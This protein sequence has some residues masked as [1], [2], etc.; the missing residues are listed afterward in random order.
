M[1]KFISLATDPAFQPFHWSWPGSHQPMHAVMIMLVDLYER[2]HSAEAPISRAY[3]DKV[4]LI[5]APDGG[6]VSG[7]DGMTVQRPLREG[8]REAWDMLKRL[9]EK[10]WQ[11]A[12]LDPDVLW[13]EEDQINVGVGQAQ[14]E[15][16]KMLQTFRDGSIYEKP[17]QPSDGS[18]TPRQSVSQA[19]NAFINDSFAQPQEPKNPPPRESTLSPRQTDPKQ[20]R[21]PQPPTQIPTPGFSV[22]PA[23]PPPQPRSYNASSTTDS[24][25]FGFAPARSQPVSA[26]PPAASI[27][28]QVT[29][30]SPFNPA[31]TPA[32]ITSTTTNNPAVSETYQAPSSVPAPDQSTMCEHFDW[33]QWDAVFGKSVPMDDMEG[34][35]LE[36]REND[37]EMHG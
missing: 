15:T 18:N 7:E 5:S 13:T 10:A 23:P 14:T 24:L 36:N 21:L 26:M 16:Q 20:E 25:P 30:A 9:R 31:P 28:N 33:D 6:I 37:T 2:P 4:F 19:V 11:R 22:A 3:I 1:R 29:T 35:D 8:G 17:R 27:P 32:S 34:L 12:G